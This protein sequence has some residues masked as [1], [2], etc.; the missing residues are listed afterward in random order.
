M[1]DTDLMLELSKADSDSTRVAILDKEIEAQQ[2][3][4]FTL[5]YD[6]ALAEGR[7]EGLLRLRENVGAPLLSPKHTLRARVQKFLEKHPGASTSEIAAALVTPVTTTSMCLGRN[8]HLFTK[9]GR[10]EWVLNAATAK[11]PDR[12]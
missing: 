2:T 12:L 5:R 9:V 3:K 10:G 11:Q 7:A 1:L 8:K 6:L 4:I